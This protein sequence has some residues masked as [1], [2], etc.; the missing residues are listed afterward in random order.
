MNQSVGFFGLILMF[1]AA[2]IAYKR[3]YR[4]ARFYILATSFYFTGVIIFILKTFALI[5]YSFFTDKSMEIGSALEMVLFSIALADR[6][7]IYKAQRE[8]ALRA[9]EK[10]VKEQNVIL[11]RTVA[12][13]TADLNL[14]KEK[15]EKL[16]LN[17][18]PQEIAEELKETG[19]AHARSFSNVAIMFTDFANFTEI[20]SRLTATA[21]VSEINFF[22][23]AFDSIMLKYRIEKIK[24][25][26]D[27]YMVAAGLNGGEI[28][29]NVTNCILA[30]IEMQKIIELRK[31][32]KLANSEA[33][34][35]MRVGLHVGD[36]VAG[37]VGDT[38]FQYDIWGDAVNTA[39]RMESSSEVGRINVSEYVYNIIN[40]EQ[41]FKFEF[42]GEIPVKGKG[43]MKMYLVSL[44]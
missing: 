1:I 21:L 4:A 26:G 20:A 32:Q 9:N 31:K 39:S 36:I 34:F 35:E 8:S 33:P 23:K 6:I 44:K 22:F 24:T 38:K 14:E 18:L 42:R 13:R 16:L 10:L 17:I 19:T 25:I 27:A 43:E 29:E 30:A 3:G 15:S 40:T 11:E 41:L 12:E 7:N 37:I 2:S 5:P 28:K